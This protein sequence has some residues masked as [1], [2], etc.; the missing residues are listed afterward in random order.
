MRAPD[1]TA[2]WEKM[3]DII[4]SQMKGLRQLKLRLNFGV[5]QLGLTDVLLESESR[6]R[7]GLMLRAPQSKVQGLRSVE[8]EVTGALWILSNGD[9]YPREGYLQNLQDEFQKELS[10][11]CTPNVIPRCV[12]ARLSPD[13]DETSSHP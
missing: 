11:I 4:G 7:I 2:T 6:K 5:P 8:L 10:A 9:T 3:W 13:G 12:A 1:D